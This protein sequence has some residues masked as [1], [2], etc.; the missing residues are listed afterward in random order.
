[1]K[2]QENDSLEYLAWRSLAD[3]YR[4]VYSK[5]NSDLRRHGLTPPQYAVLRILGKF[6]ENRSLPMNEIGRELIVTFANVTTIVDNLEKRRYVRRTKESE[7]RRIVNVELTSSG[8]ELYRKIS[9]AH[10]RQIFEFMH[11][12]SEPQLNNL[13]SSLS[14]IKNN[15][16]KSDTGVSNLQGRKKQ[17]PLISSKH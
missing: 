3:G 11:C 8:S 4:T 10:R 9:S 2:S 12:L 6:S 16:G 7:D 5:V 15:V 14:M 1:M 13:I 17:E